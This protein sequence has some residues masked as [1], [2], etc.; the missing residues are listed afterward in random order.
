MAIIEATCENALKTV[1]PIKVI[2]SGILYGYL[3]FFILLNLILNLEKC[4]N[5]FFLCKTFT[6]QL[7]FFTCFKQS[8]NL[9]EFFSGT[10][11]TN[12]L[13]A[14]V[15]AYFKH[16]KWL[17]YFKFLFSKICLYKIID[18]V[19]VRVLMSNTFVNK[20]IAK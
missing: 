10:K 2:S 1:V 6:F 15:Q 20:L 13:H 17:S 8:V 9:K 16:K 4:G 19:Y 11:I 18:M 3:D 5:F 7:N 12:N 14:N